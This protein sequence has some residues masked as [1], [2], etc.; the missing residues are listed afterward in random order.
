MQQIFIALFQLKYLNF[1]LLKIGSIHSTQN[2]V[3]DILPITTNKINY[4]R[5][6]FQERSFNYN[7]EKNSHTIKKRDTALPTRFCDINKLI[8]K[9]N[10]PIKSYQL[11]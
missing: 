3:Y 9:T 6:L 11:K 7:A 5:G 8:E 4:K 2:D 1:K 10:A